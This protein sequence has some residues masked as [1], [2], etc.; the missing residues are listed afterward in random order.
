[1]TRCTNCRF[2]EEHSFLCLLSHFHVFFRYICDCHCLTRNVPIFLGVRLAS[3]VQCRADKDKC[4][5]C[6]SHGP[7][8]GLALISSLD[9]R[10]IL[11]I[12]DPLLF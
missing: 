7:T 12:L 3:T 2:S 10:W 1:M 9:L 6:E 5:Q 11:A 8:E 4:S